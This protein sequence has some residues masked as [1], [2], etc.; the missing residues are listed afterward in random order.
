[1]VKQYIENKNFTLKTPSKVNS[2]KDKIKRCFIK[3]GNKINRNAEYSN[4]PHHFRKWLNNNKEVITRDNLNQHFEALMYSITHP[5]QAVQRSSLDE[6]K[7]AINI[8]NSAELQNTKKPFKRVNKYNRNYILAQQESDRRF[9]EQCE[10]SYSNR[11]VIICDSYSIN[12]PTKK[13]QYIFNKEFDLQ[14]RTISNDGMNPYNKR[15]IQ[16]AEFYNITDIDKTNLMPNDNQINNEYPNIQNKNQ[17][18]NTC[19]YQY[20]YHYQHQYQYKNQNKIQIQI[21]NNNLQSYFKE[22]YSPN[23]NIVYSNNINSRHY[24]TIPQSPPS[25]TKYDNN[26]NLNQKPDSIAQEYDYNLKSIHGINE[27]PRSYKKSRYQYEPF[28]RQN[29]MVFDITIFQSSPL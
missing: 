3:I 4:G 25:F 20:Q 1:M 8:N 21:Q 9:L 16:N 13:K 12:Q 17:N 14:A 2:Y 22:N 18:K 11:S 26:C 27:E 29:K 15:K 28:E 5:Q 19:T 10:R 23:Y 6:Q 7:N 24:P